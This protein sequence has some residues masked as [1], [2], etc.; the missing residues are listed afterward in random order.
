MCLNKDQYKTRYSLVERALD[1]S[2]QQ[3]WAELYNYYERFL[4][5]LVAE[6]K[7]PQDSRDDVIQEVMLK[8][9]QELP[10]YDRERGK[11][12]SWFSMLT[13]QYC[14]RFF[15]RSKT[16]KAQ[17]NSSSDEGLEF[18]S[19]ES[20][21]DDLIDKEWKRHLVRTARDRLS[22]SFRESTMEVFDLMLEGASSQEIVAHT[23]HSLHTVYNYKARL[24]EA[25]FK[26]IQQLLQ[27]VDA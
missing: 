19:T 17:M 6:L 18:I 22:E 11:F 8:V 7:I 14:W 26:T 9:T 27:E 16:H 20:A 1:L 10:K 15:K 13:R 5:Y 3:A 25:Y 4:Y 23:G 2:D 24:K 12:R 21:I